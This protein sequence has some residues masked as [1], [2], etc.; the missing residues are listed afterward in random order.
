MPYQLQYLLIATVQD[1]MI[2]IHEPKSNNE[3]SQSI[4]RH[5]P[6]KWTRLTEENRIIIMSAAAAKV[7][8]KHLT[9]YKPQSLFL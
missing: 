7:Q 6:M 8:T 4:S 9:E 2:T 5:C 3:R 1:K